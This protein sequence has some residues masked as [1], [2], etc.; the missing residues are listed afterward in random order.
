MPSAKVLSLSTVFPNPAE[1][2]LGHFIRDRLQHVAKELSVEVVAPIALIDYAAHR[3]RKPGIPVRRED[4]PIRIHHPRWFY[5]PAGGYTNAFCLAARL[6]P[7]L[8]KLRREYLFNVIDSHF[9]YPAGIAA[10][11]LSA[12]FN[13]RFTITLRGNEVLH[14]QSRR[15]ERWIGWAL[16]R[17]DRV[18]AVSENLRQFA[19]SHGVDTTRTRTIP[20][21]VDA[22]VFHAR[23]YAETRARL[24]IPE[25]RQII[26]SAGYLIERK[27]HHRV[28]RTLSELRRNGSNAELWIIGGPGREGHFEKH[29]HRAVQE[30]GLESVVHFTGNVKP[31]LLADYMSAADVVCLASSR[32]GWPNVVHEAQSCGAPVVAND[33]GGV[34]DMIP[35]ARYGFVVP[36]GDDAAL[37]SALRDALEKT[38]DRIEIAAWGRARSWRQVG[39]ETAEVLS[40]AAEQQTESLK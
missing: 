39:M 3:F 20:N 13:C 31:G 37:A 21:G 35:G 30:H 4:G 12:K 9:A 32:E 34:K 6:I 25:D 14:A 29:I 7:F 24:G 11:L 1:E 36:A 28:V 26:V 40:E 5:F 16:R 22:E 33:V 8:T 38:W 18:I 2:N 19:I 17:A 10:A 27:G 23:P 15:A